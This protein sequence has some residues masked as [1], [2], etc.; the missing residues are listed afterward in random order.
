MDGPALDVVLFER[1]PEMQLHQVTLTGQMW[2]L[3][4]EWQKTGKP[5][6]NLI[7]IEGPGSSPA[8]PG[9]LTQEQEANH[10]LRALLILSAYGT[11]RHLGWP[12]PFA[13]ASYWGESHYGSGMTERQPLLSPKVFYSAYATL[14][15]QLN[16][17]NYVKMIPTGSTTTFCLQFKHYKTG[18]LVHVFWTLRGTRPAR[19][20]V[21]K[22]GKV[23]VFDSMDNGTEE[24][25][26]DGKVG[27]TITPAPCY[28]RGLSADAKVTLGEPDHSDSKPAAGSV[29]LAE[30]GDGTWKGSAEPDTHYEGSH[31]EFV[32]RF[33]GKMSLTPVRA[34][35]ERG[36][37]LAVKLEKQEKERKV[38]PFYTTLV[39]AKPI[40]I[41]GKASHLGLW[42]KAAGDWG[43]VVYCLRD[44]KG[45]KWLA[46]G[47][48]GEWNV[49]DVHSASAFCFDGWRYLRFELPA[50]AGYDLYREAGTNG[51]GYYGPGDGLVDLP[52][53]LEKILVE[54]RTHVL[55]GTELLPVAD[56]TVLLAGLFAEYADPADK[57]DEA[58][59]QSR[60]RM[61]VPA[62][63]AELPNPIRKLAAGGVGPA[64]RVTRVAAPEREPDGTRCLVHFDAVAGAKGYDVWVSPYAD[65][66]GAVHLGKDWKEPGQLLTGLRA[67]TD[68]YLFLT[69][70]D[71]EGKP[72][73]PS[74][75]FKI[76]LKDMFPMK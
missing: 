71:R 76:N 17:V 28:V 54:R 5:W 29:R 7:S 72:S 65:G 41:P 51:W 46:V 11:T 27:F 68:F 61:P 30:L 32:R 6:P 1:M 2:Q 55:A 53:T 75:A 64:P 34:P 22:G 39:P 62:G 19:L 23:T 15:R 12:T 44:A 48:K 4:Q 74:E 18:E 69:Y 73:R 21:A 40:A 14:T 24:T 63:L 13:C 36:R 20:D 47:K 59:R 45:E 26:K 42:A 16:R 67:S 37:A 49:D 50:N 58:V 56:D 35:G 31:A 3:K 25:E 70:T 33:P 38:M 43:R 9:A 8:A 60:L 66:R 10:S 52:L 57:T